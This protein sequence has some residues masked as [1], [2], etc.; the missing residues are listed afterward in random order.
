VIESISSHREP[1]QFEAVYLLMPTTQ[2]VNRIIKDF[3]DGRQQYLGAH[4]FFVD[5]TLSHLTSASAAS[6]EDGRVL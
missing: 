2:N 1:Q 6:A 5:G 4:L 3:S